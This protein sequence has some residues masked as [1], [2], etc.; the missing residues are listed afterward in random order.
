[1]TFWVRS[2]SPYPCVFYTLL[3]DYHIASNEFTSY[4]SQG[5]QQFSRAYAGG[6]ATEIELQFL[7]DEC[8]RRLWL[9]DFLF[10]PTLCQVRYSVL[11]EVG[12]ISFTGYLEEYT[13]SVHVKIDLIS[14]SVP[15]SRGI[16]IPGSNHNMAFSDFRKWKGKN[17]QEVSYSDKWILK[18]YNAL[19][20]CLAC[21][22]Y[23][24]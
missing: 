24:K 13:I 11:L 1:L 4:S 20:F 17:C 12:K 3:D 6:T 14:R 19:L 5:W 7:D 15:Q 9:D 22:L 10:T 18:R 2:E 21:L 8:V 23:N 16:H